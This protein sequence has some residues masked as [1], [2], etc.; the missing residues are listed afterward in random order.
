MKFM[1]CNSCGNT[2]LLNETGLCL[3]CQGHL[4]FPGEDTWENYNLTDSDAT[5]YEML[6]NYPKLEDR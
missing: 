1:T 6:M 2:V 4:D 3:Q 5:N